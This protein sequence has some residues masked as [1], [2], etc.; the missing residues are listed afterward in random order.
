MTYVKFVVATA[1]LC[2]SAGAYGADLS[3]A[4]DITAGIRQAGLLAAPSEQKQNLGEVAGSATIAPLATDMPVVLGVGAYGALQYMQNDLGDGLTSFSGYQIGPEVKVGG[5]V[6]SFAP[7]AR[8]RYAFGRYTGEGTE[9]WG[10][11]PEAAFFLYGEGATDEITKEFVSQGAHVAFGT[12]FSL[13]KAVGLTAEVDLGYERIKTNSRFISND[14]EY[15]GKDV[16]AYRSQ[17]LL[18][19]GRYTL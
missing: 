12:A 14:R 5:N 19:G 7:Y 6:G 3:V 16:T 8:L 10:N 4:G 11:E 2:G 1:L 15:T 17:A 13:G 9:N 18:F